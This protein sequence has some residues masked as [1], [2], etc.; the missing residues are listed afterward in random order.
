MH[1]GH[2]GVEAE[3][4]LESRDDIDTECAEGEVHVAADAHAHTNA[5]R[6]FMPALHTTVEVVRPGATAIPP[7]GRF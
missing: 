1:A 4:E 2:D 7:L 3:L 5:R 6:G